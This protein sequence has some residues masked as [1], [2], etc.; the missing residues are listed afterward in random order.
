M[1]KIAHALDEVISGAEAR[2]R[3]ISETAAGQPVR[4]DGWS[5]KQ[6]LGHLIDSASNNHQ[7]FVRMQ[8]A[9]LL[10][11]PGYKQDDWVH[12]QSYQACLW[13]S[14]IDLWSAYNRHL[15]H[16]IRAAPPETMGN[17]VSLDGAEPVTLEFLMSDYVRHL[18]GHLRQIGVA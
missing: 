5:R 1:N 7:R 17:R 9:P 13:A 12:I 16:V 15:A 4:P 10:E 2:L 8:S 6:I 14:L 11:L 18:E 3:Q